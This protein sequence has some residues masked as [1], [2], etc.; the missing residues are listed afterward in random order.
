M[1]TMCQCERLEIQAT[2]K[3]G[4][5]LDVNEPTVLYPVNLGRHF[6]RLGCV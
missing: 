3:S 6:L 1:L 2:M 4:K 5:K